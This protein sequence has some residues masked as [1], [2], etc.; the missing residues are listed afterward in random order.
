MAD[1]NNNYF[2]F[3]D[4]PDGSGSTERWYTSDAEARAAIANLPSAA[5]IQTCE[6][7]VNELT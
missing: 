2:E 3:L 7:I 5:S 6:D 4:I 1:N